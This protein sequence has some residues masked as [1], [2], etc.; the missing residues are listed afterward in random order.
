MTKHGID[1]D[2]KAIRAFCRKWKIT[3]LAVFGSIVR[4]DFGPDSDVDFL[5]SFDESEDWGLF[6]LFDMEKE[7]GEIVGRKVD[8]VERAGV[9]RSLNYIRRKHILQTAEPILG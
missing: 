4:D 2:S 7:L 6:E 8:L 1:L 5:V 9:E 3:E